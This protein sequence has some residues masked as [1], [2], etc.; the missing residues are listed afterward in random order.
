ME[1]CR[2]IDAGAFTLNYRKVTTVSFFRLGYD[3]EPIPHRL[4]C[5]SLAEWQMRETRI[6]S[7]QNRVGRRENLR[8][9][10]FILDDNG[11]ILPERSSGNNEL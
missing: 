10:D 4:R 3:E 1:T 5:L 8:P 11:Q 9:I 7:D 6:Y 2:T